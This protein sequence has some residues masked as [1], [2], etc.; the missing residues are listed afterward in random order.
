MTTE[1]DYRALVDRVRAMVAESVPP[2][3]RLLVVSRGDDALLRVPG[4]SAE[5]FPQSMTGLY[6]GYHPSDGAEAA[7]HLAD[8]REGGAEYLVVPSTAAWWLDHYPELA[9]ELTDR[10]ERVAYEPDTCAVYALIK[11]E[12]ARTPPSLEE[13]DAARSG[14][15]A[16]ALVRALLPE[17]AGVALVGG[18]SAELDV[19]DRACWRIPAPGA[20]VSVDDVLDQ[21]EQAARAGASYVVLV[22]PEMAALRL[23]GRLRA[24]LAESRH[25]VFRQRLAEAFE[26]VREGG[27]VVA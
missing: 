19:G 1:R 14:P 3:A 8:L 17:E 6:A 18:P 9:V 13:L 27:R 10:G 12:P 16:A 2:G 15:Q 21:V 22:N 23:D 26:L 20:E 11:R 7:G 4:R 24:R 25:F 5:H